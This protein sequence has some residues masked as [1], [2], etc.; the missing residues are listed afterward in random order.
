LQEG[1]A[2]TIELLVDPR[3]I[4]E[5]QEAAEGDRLDHSFEWKVLKYNKDPPE[6]II[7]LQFSTP[8]H[9]SL[10]HPDYIEITVCGQ[11]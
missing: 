6:L 11:N 5:E 4:E 2:I 10:K 8:S 1:V 7:D 3:T 9:I